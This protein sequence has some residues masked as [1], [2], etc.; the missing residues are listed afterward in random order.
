MC[1]HGTDVLLLVPIPAHLSHTGEMRWDVKGV[2]A[3]ISPLVKALNDAAIY[4]AG[5][6]CG[7]GKGPGNIILHDGRVLTIESPG[8]A[9]TAPTTPAPLEGARERIAARLQ[10][11]R[12]EAEKYTRSGAHLY[13]TRA[14]M[15]TLAALLAPSPAPERGPRFTHCAVEH[16]AN[17]YNCTLPAGHDGEHIAHGVGW[18]ELARWPAAPAPRPPREGE[19][20]AEELE[21]IA[22]TER[23]SEALGCGMMLLP[24][25]ADTLE[26]AA[27]ALR[28]LEDR[29]RLAEQARTEAIRE[30][31]AQARDA[32]L[33][34][35]RADAAEETL[36]GAR[37][38]LQGLLAVG[39]WASYPEWR[40]AVDRAIAVERALAAES[41]EGETGRQG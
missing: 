14:E 32:G 17:G 22:R 39:S 25:S 16:R 28:T 10:A 12:E 13:L 36:Q 15:D 24:S 29:V 35:H 20:L 31:T 7:H 38:A 23:Q 3:C 27:T 6:C 9:M 2:D 37:E 21:R 33:A 40:A 18:Q 4:T 19:G 30:M 1:E 8:A 34:A 41:T 5:C 26:E 11:E